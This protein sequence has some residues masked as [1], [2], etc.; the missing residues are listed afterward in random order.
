MKT[1]EYRG[2]DKSGHSVRGLIEAISVKNVREKL[3][4][5]G[6]LAENVSLSG[7]VSRMNAGQRAVIYRQLS[8]LLGAGVPL[9]KAL[10]LLIKSPDMQRAQIILAGVRD[11][12]REGG[13]LASSFTSLC[14]SVTSF[15][16]AIIE[17]SERS[18]T[19]E[20]ML[21]RLADFIEEQEK[22]KSGVL[23]ALLYPSIVISLALIV[24]IAVLGF[25]VPWYRDM[26]TEFNLPMPLSIRNMAAVGT[27]VSYSIVPVAL[28]VSV[29]VWKLK[30]RL[31]SDASFRARWDRKLFGWP[32]IGRGYRMLVNLRFARTMAILLN[33][34]VSLIES[35]LLSGRASGSAWIAE[36]AEEE[37]ESVKHGLSLSEAVANIPPLSDSIA[38]WIQTGEASGDLATLMDKAGLQYQ[39]EW[40][41]YTSRTLTVLEPMLIL[42]VALFVLLLILPVLMSVINLSGMVG[43]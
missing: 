7:S 25:L 34:G 36:L 11:M 33:G 16:G 27:V 41:R 22:L 43:R 15:E 9:E 4:A 23:S 8:A 19:V 6:I 38:G 2:F 12:V 5:D 37:S 29:A 32:V 17:A 1:Y 35:L 40:S 3:A 28:S 10:D 42:F 30:S 20:I 26:L 18:A 21:G 24:A 31:R 39:E 13:T 14:D